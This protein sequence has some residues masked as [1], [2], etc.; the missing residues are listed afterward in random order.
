MAT[1][2]QCDAR[3]NTL[4][5]KKEMTPVVFY[6]IFVKNNASIPHTIR[7]TSEQM[8]FVKSQRVLVV[9][10]GPSPLLPPGATLLKHFRWGSETLTLD[11][12]GVLRVTLELDGRLHSFK[13]HI[14]SN[15]SE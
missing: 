2:A 12:L 6:N 9:S 15:K 13:G 11:S 7:V 3:K 5:I 14:S 1:L 4:N 8:S 10:I